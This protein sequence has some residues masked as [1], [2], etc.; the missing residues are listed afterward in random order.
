[1]RH[2]A[3]SI[4]G[5][6]H[7]ID[8]DPGN[9]AFK[10]RVR[11]GDTF[12][13]FVNEE[14]Q[15]SV[16]RNLDGQNPDRFTAPRNSKH[17]PDSPP[18]QI[19]K[20]LRKGM[21]ISVDGIYQEDGEV[22]RFDA[23]A[24]HLLARDTQ[25]ERYLF[26]ETHWWLSQIDRL[27]NQWLENLFGQKRSFIE[28]DFASLYQTNLNIL[29]LPSDDNVQEMATLSRLI[30]G[31]SSAYLLTGAERYLIA[32]RAGVA[33][34]RQTFRYLSHDGRYC[35]WAFGRRKGR[36][37][38]RLVMTSENPDDKD[39]IPLYEQIYALCGLAQYYRITA[40]WEVLEDIQRTLRAFADFY[41]DDERNAKEWGYPGLGGY[42]SHLDY[43]T[44]RP[45]A[46]ALRE[47]RSRKNWNSI[48]DHI[49]AYLINLILALDPLPVGSEG[50]P[51]IQRLLNQCQAILDETSH[52]I[53][54]KFPDPDRKIPYV[55]E[56]VLSRL[57]AGSQWGWQKNRAVMRA[58]SQD[59]VEPDTR[60]QILPGPG[61]A[62]QAR[63][64]GRT[65]QE[66]FGL[67]RSPDRDGQAPGR[68][69]G[70]ARLRPDPWR[71]L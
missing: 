64:G 57:E 10:I 69:D 2:F 7:V 1:M 42:F 56:R 31:L 58:Q 14:T 61:A 53:L 17:R 21:T 39:T 41:H 3:Q 48:G 25:T 22:R 32:A 34:Q 43:V 13:C 29:G 30:Y 45:D 12:Q 4:T 23:R 55:N 54:E 65:V 66:P 40:D 59:L 24:V 6:G 52:L 19:E 46:E 20:Y 8:T 60:G 38:T 70:R 33:F 27:I 44:M 36:L 18:Y 68:A 37:G 47:N 9:Y 35:F 15:F 26:E 28:D 11:S 49:P 50:T 62:G 5:M 67:R 63:R 16:L 71:S 51:G